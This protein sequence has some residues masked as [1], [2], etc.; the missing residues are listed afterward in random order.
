LRIKLDE[1]R[2]A[3]AAQPFRDPGH[4]VDTVIDEHL[5]GAADD[6]LLRA[7]SAAGRLLVTLDRG[8][9]DVRAHRPGSHAG[10]L[11]LRVDDQSPPAIVRAVENLVTEVGLDELS[12]CVSV[13]REGNL[14]VRRPRQ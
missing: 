13:F 6:D 14:R 2:P 1:N 10:V 9:G 7:A 3:G 11:V 4:D 12:S 5:A 8:F